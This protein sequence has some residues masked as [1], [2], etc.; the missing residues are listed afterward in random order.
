VTKSLLG[1]IAYELEGLSFLIRN[2]RASRPLSAMQAE[3]FKDFQF[4]GL[5]KDRVNEMDELHK[6]VREGRG[7]NFWRKTYLKQS[8]QKVCCIA[9]NSKGK[10]V[11]FNYYYFR[12]SEVD[13]GIIHDA[14]LGISP[15]EWGQGLATALQ[16]YAVAQFSLQN[17]SGISGNVSK[18]NEASVRMLNRVGFTLTDDPQDASNNQIFYKL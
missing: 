1:K 4:S 16:S 8:G 3:A 13:D 5:P 2:L 6:L 9:T 11:G 10:L 18:S 7:L 14:Y 12:E 17:L 15:E